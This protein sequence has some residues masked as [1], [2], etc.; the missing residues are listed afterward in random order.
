M[1]PE[2]EIAKVSSNERLEFG[3]GDKT[4]VVIDMGCKNNIIRSLLERKIKVI[5]VPWNDNL[6]LNYDGVLIS[7]GPGN[8]K[9]AEPTIKTI[10]GLFKKNV[11]IFG[12][13]MGNQVMGLAAM[14]KLIASIWTPGTKSTLPRKGN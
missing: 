14:Q 8:P 2:N 1:V 11:P 10:Q 4:V 5:R 3:S 13:C 12:I 9:F 6:E 7:N